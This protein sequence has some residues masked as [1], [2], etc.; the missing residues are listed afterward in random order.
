MNVQHLLWITASLQVLCMVV[1]F[2]PVEPKWA[3]FIQL[4]T[5]C[6]A[7]YLIHFNYRRRKLSQES[8]D[9]AKLIESQ[10][11]DLEKQLD[12]FKSVVDT[13]LGAISQQLDQSPPGDEGVPS[14]A[15][16]LAHIESI[17]REL[18]EIQEAQAQHN[19]GLESSI[20]DYRTHSANAADAM[21]QRIADMQDS[22]EKVGA[23]FNEVV[24]QVE[25]VTKR[26]QDMEEITS[27]TNLLALNA[28][29][30][31]ARAGEVGRGFAVVADEVRTLSQRTS[32]FSG[33]IRTVIDSASQSIHSIA[34]TMSGLSR[35]DVTEIDESRESIESM[36]TQAL[37]L[38]EGAQ[39]HSRNI[40]RI[41]QQLTRYITESGNAK[42][43]TAMEHS[44]QTIREHV[45]ALNTASAEFCDRSAQL[46]CD[47]LS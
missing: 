34:D 32:Q 26:L 43:Q 18:R 7:S 37:D 23:S 8:E 30:E 19:A 33:E 27:Q 36:W 22:C 28:A 10:A 42:M 9:Q 12:Q 39:Q 44:L 46:H 15:E 4:L 1:L 6:T 35:I 24:T 25:S 38:Q 47:D 41:T 29:I 3:L 45:D 16:K 21:V 2:M 5:L 31:A 40:D 14:E 17:N 11:V 20:G 13:Q